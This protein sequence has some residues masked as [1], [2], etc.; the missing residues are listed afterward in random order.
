MRLNINVYTI[1]MDYCVRGGVAVLW[2]AYTSHK[3]HFDKSYWV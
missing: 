3:S 1:E 2:A